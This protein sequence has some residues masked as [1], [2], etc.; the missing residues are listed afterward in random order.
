MHATHNRYHASEQKFVTVLDRTLSS[1]VE[2]PGQVQ[3]YLNPF[4]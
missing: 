1:F 3:G 4:L 2:E